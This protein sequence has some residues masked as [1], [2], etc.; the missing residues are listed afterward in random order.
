MRPGWKSQPCERQWKMGQR[1]EYGRKG[2]QRNQPRR[3]ACTSRGLQ[4]FA[5]RVQLN[6]QAVSVGNMSCHMIMIM[7]LDALFYRHEYYVTTHHSFPR[8]CFPS[9]VVHSKQCKLFFILFFF[10]SCVDHRKI[11]QM[12]VSVWR[13]GFV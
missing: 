9:P 4:V 13:T 3:E 5:G 1:A 7:S 2:E 6:R 11:H 10:F 12:Q 8:D